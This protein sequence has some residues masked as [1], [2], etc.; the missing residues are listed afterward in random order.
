MKRI[1]L[2]LFAVL[3]LLCLCPMNANAESEASG[4]TGEVRWELKDKVLT[5]SG[6]GKMQDYAKYGAPWSEYK[7]HIESIVIEEGVTSIGRYSFSWFD[8]VRKIDFPASVT[9]IGDYAFC[10]CSVL[11]EIKLPGSVTM[12][13]DYAFYGCVLRE[14][15]LPDGITEIGSYAFCG[16]GLSEIDIPASVSSIGYRAF[17]DGELKKITVD[18]ENEAYCSVDGVLFTK[19]MKTL[20]RFA[21]DKKTE[22]TVPDGVTRIEDYAFEGAGLIKLSFPESVTSIG[23]YAFYGCGIKELRLPEKLTDIGDKMFKCLDDLEVLV[24]PGSVSSIHV[25]TF[26][27]IHWGVSHLLCEIQVDGKNQH[28]CSVDGVLF[29]KD[30][31]TLVLY[32][33]EKMPPENGRYTIPDGV[34]AIGDYAFCGCDLKEICIPESVT[35]IGDYAFCT[36]LDLTE[37]KLPDG[38]TT[39]GDYAFYDCCLTELDLPDCLTTIGD[40]AFD[41]WGLTGMV[42][43]GS[44][45]YIGT[46]AF[47]S[48]SV[49]VEKENKYYCSKDGALLT[50]DGKTLLSCPGGQVP[51]GVTTIG[52]YALYGC[53][54]EIEIPKSVT[55]IDENDFYGVDWIS[56]AEGNKA[57]KSVDGVLFSADG[58]RLVRFPQVKELGFYK[59]PDGVKIIGAGAFADCHYLWSIELPDG[60]VEIEEEAFYLNADNCYSIYIPRSV[61]YIGEDAFKASGNEWDDPY[62]CYAGTYEQWEAVKKE[63]DDLTDDWCAV[64]TGPREAATVLF[65]SSRE[66]FHE[67]HVNDEPYTG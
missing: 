66:S 63:S 4:Q 41:A 19:D 31:K 15:E 42:I 29:T 7:G 40:F 56:V 59:V 9:E 39:I 48:V 23:D 8:A 46:G 3:F 65:E 45:R 54:P 1:S 53:G 34:T 27:P 35:S 25:V 12:I 17:S 37:L 51:D 60:L 6:S 67:E 44:V 20:I 36:C 21:G 14:I 61:A 58:K 52:E 49:T 5:I 62:L 10:Y 43:P 38:L 16:N 64:F 47:A 55:R 28:Y 13:G 33:P 57:F 24:I 50:R 26:D 32:P 2:I 22:Y 18:E 30:M 11:A